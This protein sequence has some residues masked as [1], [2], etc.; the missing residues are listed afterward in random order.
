MVF[1]QIH[2]KKS[3]FMRRFSA[4]KC[5]F[6]DKPVR[7]CPMRLESNFEDLM[8]K[9]ETAVRYERETATEKLQRNEKKKWENFIEKFQ[10]HEVYGC[11]WEYL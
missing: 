3:R 9:E 8:P 6:F 4:L 1:R 10:E 7:M 5:F 2:F 11:G